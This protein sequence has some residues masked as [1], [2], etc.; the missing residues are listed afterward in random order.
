M[1]DPDAQVRAPLRIPGPPVTLF[2]SPNGIVAGTHYGA[3]TSARQV[4]D[5]MAKHLGIDS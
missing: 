1:A 5:A 4:Q 3:F 2:V